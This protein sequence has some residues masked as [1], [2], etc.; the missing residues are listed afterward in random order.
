MRQCFLDP[1]Q[2]LE[3]EP[4]I[5]VAFGGIGLRRERA[6][7][8]HDGLVKPTKVLGGDGEIVVRHCEVLI[9]YNGAP[10]MCRSVVEA[11]LC[12]QRISEMEMRHDSVRIDRKRGLKRR[13]R[14]SDPPVPEQRRTEI[15]ARL[16]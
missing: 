3:S 14:F 13:V 10:V 2:L 11:A 1:P 7:V 9:D 15:D 12:P 8:M 5:V 4:E 16:D 6:P